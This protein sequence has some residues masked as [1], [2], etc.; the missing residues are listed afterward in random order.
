MEVIPVYEAYK[1]RGFEV[2]G[3]AR[4]YNPVEVLAAV[5]KDNTPWLTLV[6]TQDESFSIW[7][8]YGI[9]NAAGG[10]FLVDEQGT[11]I[12]INP[13]IEDLEQILRERLNVD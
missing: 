6:A 9:G 10:D 13:S 3:V 12:A 5:V 8:S 2:I 11:I 4:E 1:N 7:V